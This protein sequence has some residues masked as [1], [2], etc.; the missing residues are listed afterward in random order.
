M[1][2]CALENLLQ[3]YSDHNELRARAQIVYNF[4]EKFFL[5]LMGILNGKTRSWVIPLSL[6]VS[7]YLLLRI[8]IYIFI[9]LR[10]S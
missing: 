1:L 3:K 9:K 8:I 2:R 10:G 7:Y 6:L 4:S 5:F